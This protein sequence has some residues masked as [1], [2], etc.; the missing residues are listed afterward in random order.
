MLNAMLNRTIRNTFAMLLMLG[1]PAL[2]LAQGS[3]PAPASAGAATPRIQ[4]TLDKQSINVELVATIESRMKGLMFREK[5]AKNDG[6][7]F[8]FDEVG[9]HGMWMK[10]TLIPLSV[11][12]IDAQG[13]ILNIADMEPHSETTHSAAGPALYA[14]EMNKGWFKQHGIGPGTVVKGLDKAPKGR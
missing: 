3:T 2:A 1:A 5:M 11:A 4:L 9:Y 8:V 7:L 13:K 14:L 10:N 6:M 12:F